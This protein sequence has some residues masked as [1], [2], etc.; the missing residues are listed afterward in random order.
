MRNSLSLSISLENSLDI[1]ESSNIFENDL[2]KIKIQ[3]EHFNTLIVGHFNINSVRK[4]FDILKIITFTNFD[5]FLILES[6]MNSAPPNMQFKINGYKLLRR[7]CNR[8]GRGLMLYE[9]IPCKF[10]NNHP[11]VPNGFVLNF[12]N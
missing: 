9:E 10:L 5:I 1:S 6:K 4:K 7:D 11:I 3:I 12:I 2:N 8:F